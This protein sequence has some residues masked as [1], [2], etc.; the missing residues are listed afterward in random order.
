MVNQ[1]ILASDG[2]IAGQFV[3][4]FEDARAEGIA[5]LGGKTYEGAP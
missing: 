4:Q 1:R 3:E 2:S 5:C